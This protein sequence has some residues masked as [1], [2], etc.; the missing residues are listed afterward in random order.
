MLFHTQNQNKIYFIKKRWLYLQKKYV[1]SSISYLL[2]LDLF[3]G[4]MFAVQFVL[5]TK[6]PVKT[7][8]Q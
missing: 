5:K 1:L 6:N 3:V 4:V 8:W 2:A 7:V